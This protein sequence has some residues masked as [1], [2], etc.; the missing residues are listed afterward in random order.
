MPIMFAEVESLHANLLCD[1]FVWRIKQK[2]GHSLHIY[3]AFH[4]MNYMHSA[5]FISKGES[6][7]AIGVMVGNRQ[8]YFTFTA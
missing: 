4:G 3:I 7:K 2:G 8:T 1:V 6:K 5:I